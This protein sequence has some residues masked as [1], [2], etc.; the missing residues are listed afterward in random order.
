MLETVN[1]ALISEFLNKQRDVKSGN[2]F[3][4]GVRKSGRRV[5]LN[6]AY[7]PRGEYLLLIGLPRNGVENVLTDLLFNE[8]ASSESKTKFDFANSLC[9]D[10]RIEFTASTLAEGGTDSWRQEALVFPDLLPLPNL[11]GFRFHNNFMPVQYRGTGAFSN[12]EKQFHQLFRI[13]RAGAVFDVIMRKNEIDNDKDVF[14]I[15]IISEPGNLRIARLRARLVE[16]SNP[17]NNDESL[18]QDLTS[19]ALFSIANHESDAPVDSETNA[20]FNFNNYDFLANS[21]NKLFRQFRVKVWYYDD[22]VYFKEGAAGMNEPFFITLGCSSTGKGSLVGGGGGFG[23]DG[24]NSDKNFLLAQCSPGEPK[25][26]RATNYTC[27][28]SFQRRS[29]ETTSLRCCKM[30]RG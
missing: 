8:N 2:E 7:V 10:L 17:E 18:M 27:R 29:F 16:V 5:L 3:A 11:D 22:Q 1:V 23:S 24:S 28:C 30:D 12:N 19:S 4:R 20:N 13:P 26:W 9:A 25:R 15:R 21:A 14:N 6:T